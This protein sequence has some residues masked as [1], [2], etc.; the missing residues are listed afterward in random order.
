[1][2]LRCAATPIPSPD[3]VARLRRERGL[4]AE[5]LAEMTARY[6][7]K[8]RELSL[9]RHTSEALRDCTDLEEVFRRL[10]GIVL[11]ELAAWVK[12]RAGSRRAATR[13]G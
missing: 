4:Y 2:T 10:V 13:A 8:V 6:E 12:S 7:Q 3:E 1:M 11:D 9:V 5:A